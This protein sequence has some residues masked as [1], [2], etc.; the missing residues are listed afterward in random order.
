VRYG[1]DLPGQTIA[2]D[3]GDTHRNKCLEALALYG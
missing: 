2:P 3:Q 1:L